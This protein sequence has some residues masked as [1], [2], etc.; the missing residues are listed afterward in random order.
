MKYPFKKPLINVNQ[1]NNQLINLHFQ[2]KKNY[3]KKN[4][5][6]NLEKDINLTNIFYKEKNIALIYKNEI[7]IK[8]T[9]VEYSK[10]QKAKIIQAYFNSHSLP[11]YHGLYKGRFLSFDVKETSH[12][13]NFP[14]KNIPLHQISNLQKIHQLNGISFFIINFKTKNKYFY[15]PINFLNFY[16]KNS[17]FKSINYKIFE[18]KMFQIPFG[19]YPRIDYLKIVDK[20]IK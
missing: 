13:T 15:L 9:K 7:P 1:K 5:G 8:I 10:R 19:Y 4:L 17:N 2:K 12:K 6:L 11:D 14:L 20:F 18:T 16:L 3:N